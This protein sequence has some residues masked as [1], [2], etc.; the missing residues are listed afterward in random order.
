MEP[1]GQACCHLFFPDRSLPL[2]AMLLG[3][4]AI[5]TQGTELFCQFGLMIKQRSPFPITGVFSICDGYRGY[6]PTYEAV[7]GGG[8]SGEPIYWTR[9]APATGY[10]IVDT[11]CELL[12]ALHRGDTDV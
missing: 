9:F 8:Y 5:V 11:A 12:H 1:P 7:L 3:P 10:R 4:A 6:C 2:H